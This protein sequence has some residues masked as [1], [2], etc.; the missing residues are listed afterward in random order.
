MSSPSKRR[1]TSP[2]TYVN[3]GDQENT[4]QALPK[5]TTPKRAS[6]QSPTK[7]SLARSNPKVLQEVAKAKDRRESEPNRR[8]SLRDAVLGNQR[9]LP[10]EQR[11]R[12]QAQDTTMTA[13]GEMVRY[14]ASD[15]TGA[16]SLA[17]SIMD[18]FKDL[19]STQPAPPGEIR[20]KP[21]ASQQEIA[22]TPQRNNIS[23]PSFTSPSIVPRLV[24]ST[25]KPQQHSQ[26]STSAELPPTPVQLGDGVRVDRPRGL[27]SSSPGGGG[28]RRIRLG[29]GHITSSPLK[30]KQTAPAPIEPEEDLDDAEAASGIGDDLEEE[31]ENPMSDS[32]LDPGET[33]DP[34]VRD[35]QQQLR[36]LQEG[37][38][39]LQEQCDKLKKISSTT[40]QNKSQAL[41]PDK[42]DEDLEY[43]LDSVSKPTKSWFPHVEDHPLFKKNT[44]T[45]LTLFSPD[46]LQLSYQCWQETTK[47]RNKIV[48]QT[49]F[50]APEPWPPNI[51]SLTFDVITD[52][53]TR[54]TEDIVFANNRY[55]PPALQKWIER[56]LSLPIFKTD[57][58]TLVTGIGRY[59]EEDV[60]RA[61]TIKCLS[62]K[63]ASTA[64]ERPDT[65]IIL[66]TAQSREDALTL[67]PYLNT[68]QHSFAS[69]DALAQKRTRHSLGPTRQLMLTYE[70]SLDWIGQTSTALDICASGFSSDAVQSA[71][72]LF[73]EIEAVDG[74]QAAFEGVWGVLGMG[75]DVAVGGVGATADA[76]DQGQRKGKGKR[77]AR[78][79]TEFDS[80]VKQ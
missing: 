40:S 44:G 19:P 52:Q 80:P 7:A 47:T 4:D 36:S 43:L 39:A 49:T 62:K 14:A 67:L 51:L 5:P 9:I 12:Q 37:L 78:R 34:T 22:Y 64:L 3:V 56:R 42:L 71:R 11:Q 77:K 21:T 17:N 27:A 35:K 15:S 50:A 1:R 53:E 28:R 65:D 24:Q 32:G 41:S 29:D 58:A 16:P 63:L 48:Y 13:A 75:E 46:N 25:S 45:Y 70:I 26:R 54:E 69:G 74:V 72:K 76:K 66:R 10:E 18:A 33:D 60:R 31:R 6:Y 55:Q 57:L 59:F 20:P 23:L 79:M 8:L 2:T 38:K 68:P 30:P 73:R 61:S